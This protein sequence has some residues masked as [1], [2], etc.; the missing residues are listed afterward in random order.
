MKNINPLELSFDE[1]NYKND[2]YP[3]TTIVMYVKIKNF[4]LKKEVSML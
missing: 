4:A 1:Y 2:I 3:L